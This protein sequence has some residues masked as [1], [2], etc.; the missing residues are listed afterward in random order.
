MSLLKKIKRKILENSN[1]FNY[2]KDEYFYSI[3]KEK[4]YLLKIDN[5]KSEISKKNYEI[6]LLNEFI[7]NKNNISTSRY[8]SIIKRLDNLSKD[9]NVI[10]GRFDS[11]D[12]YFSDSFYSSEDFNVIKSKLDALLEDNN[13]ISGRFD[14]LDK[15]S[16]DL[17]KYHEDYLI[18]NDKLN[19][20][21]DY[22][23]KHYMECR[24]Y[25]F[26][27]YEDLIK[28]YMNTDF[29]FN[30]C[31]FNN[32]QFLS[33]SPK[34]NRLLLK[35]ND[36]IIF[37]TNNHFW[38]IMEVYGL[39]EYSIPQL[40]SFDDFVV[41]DIGMNRAYATLK[42]ANY[43]NCSAVYGFEIDKSTY[44]IA[45]YNINLNP[46]IKHK[47]TP[48]NIGL[49]DCDEFVDLYY[50]DGFDGLNTMIPEFANIHPDLKVKKDVI[51][52]KR[53]EVKKTTPIINEIISKINSNSKIVLKI[54][55]EGAEYKIIGDL[56]DSGLISKFDVIMGEGHIFSDDNIKNQLVNIGFNVVIL[57]ES[58]LTYSFALVKNEYYNYWHLI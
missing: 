37:S 40:Y 5:L 24:K 27:G 17:L 22:S 25:F 20:F 42:F 10:S 50:I 57:N 39:N 3:S 19:N 54:D 13:V 29:L 14:N 11:V 16:R 6:K 26:N 34:E 7:E 32:I 41:I 45:L 56:I 1:S 21:L 9:N 53:V 23:T 33:F 43:E 46:K 51:K 35:S 49:S 15:F 52:T 38:T 44:D 55:T 12:E 47:I 31:Y 2:Y 36:N 28:P 18:I 4:D 8:E 48:Y 30:I 58:D